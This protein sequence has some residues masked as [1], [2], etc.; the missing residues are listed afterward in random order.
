MSAAD[1]AAAL[2]DAHREGRSWRC[3]CPLH[4]GRSLVLRDGSGGR[5][6]ATC[7]GGCDRI[8]VLA[9]LRAQGLLEG[10]TECSAPRAD[11]PRRDDAGHE[12]ARSDRALAI[13]GEARPI[14]G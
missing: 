7:W 6:L 2:G 12:A 14:A 13:L 1:V 11:Q 10:R 8:E 3:R 9:E 5:L 4:G